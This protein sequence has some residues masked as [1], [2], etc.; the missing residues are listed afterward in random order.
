MEGPS[1]RDLSRVS[2][3]THGL[4]REFLATLC[5]CFPC[6]SVHVSS[7]RGKLIVGWRLPPE[8]PPEVADAQKKQAQDGFDE[9]VASSVTRRRPDSIYFNSSPD[10]GNMWPLV[11]HTYHASSCIAFPPPSSRYTPGLIAS[12]SQDLPLV[13]FAICYYN[14]YYHCCCCCRCYPPEWCQAAS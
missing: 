10:R 6:M 11:S 7:H 2:E 14:N 3:S 5:L 4:S 8:T 9:V 13:R 12:W 1:P